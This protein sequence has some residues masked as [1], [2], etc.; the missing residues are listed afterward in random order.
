LF[1]QPY[2]RDAALIRVRRLHSWDELVGRLCQ[3]RLFA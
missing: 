3:L 2:N 1:D